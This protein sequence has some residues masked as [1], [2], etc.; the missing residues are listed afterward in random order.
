MPL[1]LDG[2]GYSRKESPVDPEF[3]P[4]QAF[5]VYRVRERSAQGGEDELSDVS[6]QILEALRAQERLTIAK[7][8]SLT[9]ANRNTLKV[10]LRE[11]VSEGRVRQHGKARATWYS[12]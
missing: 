5:L 1:I 3:V 2:Q 9:G 7:L 11:L 12:L 10:R 6:R 4:I 8:A